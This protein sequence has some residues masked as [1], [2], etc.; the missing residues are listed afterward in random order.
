MLVYATL[1][2]GNWSF[3]DWRTRLKVSLESACGML[4]GTNSEIRSHFYMSMDAMVL[5]SLHKSMLV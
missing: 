4:L 5:K 3:L 2:V 1:N